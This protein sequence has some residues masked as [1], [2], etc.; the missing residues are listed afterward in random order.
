MQEQVVIIG[1]GSVYFT[2]KLAADLIKRQEPLVLGLVDTDERA[3][4]TAERLIRKMV[5]LKDAPVEVR[6]S[7][8]R[9]EL[10]PGAT[11]VITTI[12]VGG[13]EAGRLDRS[14]AEKYG[15]YHTGGGDSCM[16]GATSN[17]LR[18]IPPSVAIAGDVLDLAPQALFMNYTNPMSAVCRA[19]RRETGAEVIGLCTGTWD[20][21]E[22]LAGMLGA[23]PSRMRYNAVGINHCTW[24]TEIRVDGKDVKPRLREI[25]REHVARARELSAGVDDSP[26]KADLRQKIE[27]LQPFSWQLFLLLDAF[28][29][30]YDWHVL[31]FFPHLMR[32]RNRYFGM[33]Q[34]WQMA[35]YRGQRHE[36]YERMQEQAFSSAPLPEDYL[37]GIPGVQEYSVDMLYSVRR[38]TGTVYS[39][40]LPNRGR[41]PELPDECIIEAPAM[42]TAGGLRPLTQPP[43]SPGLLGILATR[44]QWVEVTVE[45]AIEG[46]RD[47][48]VQALILDGAVDS[49]DNAELLADELIAAHPQ[50]LPQFS[51]RNT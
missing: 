33:T 29:A 20:V 19:V 46:S 16:P 50:H 39:T 8:D 10:L 27:D 32:G 26:E 31:E 9:R 38:D 21:G 17:A 13:R 5:A 23:E 14:I 48:V 11:V 37:E 28:P 35:Q 51:T 47:K 30:A 44:F 6:A 25:A 12:A 4:E 41:I 45:A 24:F 49:Y 7:T 40:N 18:V 15:I 42:A 34:G 43:L 36:T 2:R 1:A 22:Y 3:C